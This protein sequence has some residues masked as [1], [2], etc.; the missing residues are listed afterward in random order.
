M[1]TLAHSC[2]RRHTNAHSAGTQL[3]TQKAGRGPWRCSEAVARMAARPLRQGMSKQGSKV[4]VQHAVRAATGLP[5]TC[6]P[7]LAHAPHA[8]ALRMLPRTW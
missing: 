5:A 1:H 7:G 6:R 2:A 3:R 4:T 8:Y